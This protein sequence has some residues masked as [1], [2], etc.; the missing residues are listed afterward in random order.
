[1]KVTEE[2][3]MQYLDGNLSKEEAH[4]VE[5][6]IDED[7]LLKKLFERHNAI[8]QTLNESSVYS[9]STDFTDSVMNAVR[10]VKQSEGKFFNRLRLISLFLIVFIVVTSLYY[11]G[12]SFY[13]TMGSIMT[14]EISLREFTVNM[15]PAKDL[16][17]SDVL[18]KIVLYV[19]GIIGLFLL[20]RAVLKPYFTRRRQRYSV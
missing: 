18:F 12:V 20:D 14:D 7:D 2:L 9:P 4:R 6:A 1:M 10:L 13:P 16:L 8:H 5:I 19:N 17:N 3:I 15:K 11:L